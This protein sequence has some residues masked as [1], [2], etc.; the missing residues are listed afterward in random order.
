M[1]AYSRKQA[2]LAL[3]ENKMERVDARLAALRKRENRFPLLRLAVFLAGGA[4]TTAAFLMPAWWLGWAA[5][6]LFLGVFS[7]VAALHRAVLRAIER[8]QVLREVTTRQMARARL[9]WEHIPPVPAEYACNHPFE[10]DLNI[11]GPNS[12]HQLLDTAASNGGSERLRGWMLAEEPDPASTARRQQLAGELLPLSGFR[13][14]LMLAS[15]LVLN[16]PGE[17]WDGERLLAWL[18][19]ESKA[20]AL[21]TFLIPLT[22]VAAANITAFVLFA[23]GRVPAV[24]WMAILV[25]FWGLQGMKYRET[26]EL[27]GE[28]YGLARSLDQFHAVMRE[29]EN[30][31]YRAGSALAEVARPFYEGERR[32]SRSLRRLSWIVS[33]AGLRNNPFLGL[34]LNTLLPWDMFFTYLL[35]RYKVHLRGALP[36]WL[37]AWYELEAVNSL[38]NFALLNPE[39]CAPETIAAGGDASAPVF[40]ARE[41]GHPLLPHESRVSN[42][43]SIQRLGEMFIITGSNMSGKSTFLRTI[44]VNLVLANAGAVVCAQHLSALPFRLYTCINLSDSLSDGISYFYAE[45]RRLKGLLDALNREDPYPLF[46][47]IDEIFRGTNNRERQQGSQA[48]AQALVGKNGTGLISTHDLELAKIAEHLDGVSNYHFREEV[49]DGRMVFDYRL[50]PGSSPTTN[51]LKIMEMEG[52]P[53]ST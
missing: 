20:A 39:Y 10:F 19:R 33:A 13:D 8:Y 9:D 28:A 31:P 6:A 2:R 7:A 12:L 45:V 44:G 3:L 46:F 52:L 47:L 15:A 27:F 48:Y 34:M 51:A 26:S 49:R 17:R 16:H 36:A 42:T 35:E 30:Y 14:R 25:I 23:L 11:T 1:D 22:L 41:I 50:R 21:R 24:T 37:D 29:L 18:G 4:L 40:A 43:F 38:A 5:L 53:T 32:P